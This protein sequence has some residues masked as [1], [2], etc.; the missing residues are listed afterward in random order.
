MNL[1]FRTELASGYKS[2]SQIARVVSEDWCTRELYCAA[3]NSNR[4]SP[5]SANTPAVDFI[6]PECEQPFQLKSLKT[7]NQKAIPDAAYDSMVRKIRSD[8]T[9]NLLVLQYSAEWLVR[10]LLLIPNVFFTES[11]LEKRAPL[12]S[13]ARRAG[14]VGCNI[15]LGRIPEDGKI[16]MISD[17]HPI[18]AECVRHQFS[19]VRELVRVPPR[20]RGW[21]VDVLNSIRRLEKPQFSL[22][23]LYKFESELKA[24]HPRNENVRP[25]IRQ[26]LQVLRDLGL[27]QFTTPGS[28]AVRT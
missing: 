19:R 1:R 15:L 5:S 8:E 25:K 11:V 14:W 24:L 9:P 12:N 3:C 4:L 26:Q 28:Y 16:T 7:W 20:M 27:I 17:S 13:R 22:R 18:A 2:P 10:N 21:T 6:C 23:E